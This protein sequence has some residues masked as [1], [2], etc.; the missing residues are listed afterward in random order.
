MRKQPHLGIT[1]HTQNW[2]ESEQK[3][4]LQSNPTQTW[5]GNGAQRN[6]LSMIRNLKYLTFLPTYYNA[7][8]PYIAIYLA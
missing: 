1:L 8:L 4:P 3:D 2:E 6:I 7:Y 5:S